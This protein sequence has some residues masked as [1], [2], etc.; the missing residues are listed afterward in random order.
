MKYKKITRLDK[1]FILIIIF[2]G[3]YWFNA[4]IRMVENNEL[5]SWVTIGINVLYI[6]TI[7]IVFIFKKFYEEEK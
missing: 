3:G 2:G 1:F 5:F 6:F 4:L 7:P